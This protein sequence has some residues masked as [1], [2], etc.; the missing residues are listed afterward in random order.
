MV[1]PTG[2]LALLLITASPSGPTSGVSGPTL[3]APDGVPFGNAQTAGY[4]GVWTDEEFVAVPPEKPAQAEPAGQHQPGLSPRKHPRDSPKI[5][6][7]L[8][9]T[10][11]RG[12]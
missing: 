11:R 9:V 3:G 7:A 2:V 6:N 10:T 8:A 12:S 4:A 5:L 1:G